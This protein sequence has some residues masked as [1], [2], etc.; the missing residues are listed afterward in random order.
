M[1]FALLAQAQKSTSWLDGESKWQLV[2]GGIALLVVGFFL[3]IFFSFF[4]LG[5]PKPDVAGFA[6]R[7]S[8]PAGGTQHIKP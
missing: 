4:R 6:R 1:F 5:V 2:V 7:I 8:G 3:V